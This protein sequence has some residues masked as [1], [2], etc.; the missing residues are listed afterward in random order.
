[1]ANVEPLKN[2]KGEITSYRIRVHKGRDLSGKRLKPY[3]MLF[4]F[5]KEW[6]ENKIQKELNKAIILFEQQCN[7]GYAPDK[8]QSF[9]EYAYYVIDLKE[10][11]EK[12]KHRTIKGYKELMGRIKP[13]IGHLKLSD[14]KPQHLNKF[15]EQ[16]SKKGMNL[17][18]GGYLS[19]KSILEYHRFIHTV[20]A[21]AEKEML[22][23]YN[24]A[25]KATPP[26]VKKVE[27]NYLEIEDILKIL[28]Y[29]KN[30]S[31]KWQVA[32]NLLAFTGGRRGEIAGIKINK[33]NFDNNTIEIVESLLYSS[34]KGLYK[35]TL[36]N[37]Y[38]NRILKLPE[39][40]MSLIKQ[41]VEELKKKPSI[42]G[43]KWIK[44]GYLLTQ[45]NGAPMHP[46]S[47]TSYCSDFR[48]KYNKKIR[49]DEE[50]IKLSEDEINKLLVPRMNP[51]S[52]RHAQASILIFS[53]ADVISVSKRLGHANPTITQNVYSHLMKKADENI[54]DTLSGVLLN[55]SPKS[56]QKH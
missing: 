49:E 31:L 37:E 26:K 41:L 28:E 45:E 23:V 12:K 7:E 3:S 2:K 39:E 6:S 22:V 10:N 27:A 14:I 15:Y 19:A 40:I 48:E 38:S 55:K 30:E 8:K 56:H 34:E 25:S 53:G 50:N 29:A 16:L 11:V 21:Q 9:E 18:T 47:I 54:A 1:M 32:L 20:L 51:H 46:D 43:D 52:F 13:A 35:D 4:K 36:K 33:I 5:K 17:K 42:L 44:S 24:S